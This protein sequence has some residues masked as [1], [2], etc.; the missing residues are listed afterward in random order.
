MQKQLDM[1][2][3]LLGN[4]VLAMWTF[5]GFI[6]VVYWA[7]HGQMTYVLFS[8]MV[9]LFGATTIIMDVLRL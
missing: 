4:T 6:G 5:G 8:V 1:I 2:G 3:D 9:P 7:V